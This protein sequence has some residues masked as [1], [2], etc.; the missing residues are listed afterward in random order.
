MKNQIKPG[1]QGILSS[2]SNYLVTKSKTNSILEK[3]ML[4]DPLWLDYVNKTL[5]EIN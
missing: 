4:A 2:L 5:R 1:Y 3:F